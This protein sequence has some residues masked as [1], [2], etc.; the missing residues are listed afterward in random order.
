MV[1]WCLKSKFKEIDVFCIVCFCCLVFFIS[2]IGFFFF[3]GFVGYE[4]I[5]VL[6]DCYI[7][8]INVEWEVIVFFKKVKLGIF[9]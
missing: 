4:V 3:Y 7:V 1:G 2:Y 9:L 6:I 5:G 8:G